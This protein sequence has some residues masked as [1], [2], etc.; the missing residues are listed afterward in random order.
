MS[1]LP[2]VG[3]AFDLNVAKASRQSSVNLFLRPM[4]TPSKASFILDSIRGLI[5]RWELG[6]EIRGVYRAGTR[7]FAVAGSTLYELFADYTSTNR[8]TLLTSTG[9][10]SMAYGLTQLVIVDGA[11]GYVLALSTNVFAQITDTDWP[12]SATV[13]FLDNYFLFITPSTQQ[14]FISAINDASTLDALDFA[15]A[16]SQPDLLVAQEVMG[17]EWL[18]FGTE[19]TESW[20]NYGATDYPFQRNRS[21]AISKG[22]DAVH[23]VRPLDN[24]VAWIGGDKEGSNQVLMYRGGAPTIISTEAVSEALA[25]STNLSAAVAYVERRGKHEF[26]CISAPGVSAVWAFDAFTSQWHKRCDLDGAGQLA[27]HRLTHCVYA[28]GKTLGGDADGNV[29]ELSD[30]TYTNA[31]DALVRERISAHEAK[32]SRKWQF[33]SD[34]WL[35]CTTGESA[36]GDDP[37]VELSWSGDSG[38]TWTNPILRAVGAIGNRMPI[39]RWV[40]QLGRARDRLWKV[41]FSGNAPFAIVDANWEAREGTN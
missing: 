1:K 19:S 23:S 28:F 9:T 7:A 20:S 13:R 25:T 34:F 33:F 41:R 6:A 18:Q 4:E 29:Y 17:N 10:V 11:N 31:G 35:D 37:Q 8:G 14:A 26:Y 24:G 15:S 2:F 30:T 32:P 27:A 3:P 22:C 40:A 16:E 36:Q 5:T 21:I 38:A 39:V 12:G